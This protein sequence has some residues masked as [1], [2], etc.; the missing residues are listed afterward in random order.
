MFSSSHIFRK[1]PTMHANQDAGSGK[2]GYGIGKNIINQSSRS[3]GW[4][5]FYEWQHEGLP[6]A[7]DT[8]EI[9]SGRKP[10]D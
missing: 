6:P 5:F 10:A 8:D 7:P 4:L 2:Y 1:R 3:R 9:G